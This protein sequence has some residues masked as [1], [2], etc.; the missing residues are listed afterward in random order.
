MGRLPPK[1]SRWL[2]GCSAP[3][4]D[5]KATAPTPA[6]EL[7]L[8]TEP[9][10]VADFADQ[11]RGADRPDTRFV[12]QGGAVGV[13]EVIDVAFEAADVAA[14]GAVLVDE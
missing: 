14:G 13:E 1:S 8:A 11:C 6:S 7:G 2:L 9:V 4:P 10:R 3:S 12:T 5:D